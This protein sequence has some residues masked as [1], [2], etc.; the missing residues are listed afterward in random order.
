MV[1]AGWQR[2]YTLP[3]HSGLDGAKALSPHSQ[4]SAGQD[5]PGSTG[6]DSP[7]HCP[8]KSPTGGIFWNTLAL[9]IWE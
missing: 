8:D 2:V 7:F 3:H 4:Y 5:K 6:P 1:S 9:R